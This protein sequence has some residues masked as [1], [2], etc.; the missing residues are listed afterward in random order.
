MGG[1]GHPYAPADLHLPGFVPQQLSQGQILARYLGTSVIVF[2]AVWLLSG[3]CR[4]L[5]KTDRLLMCWWAFTGLTHIFIEG[6]FVFTPGFFRKENPNYLDEVWK[7][8]S[9]AD[10]RYVA[11]DPAIV[12]VEGSTAVLGGPASLLA[13]YAIAS[14]KSYSHILQFTVC[15]GHLYGGL[16]Y[17]I[18]AYLDGFNFWISPFYFWA[19]FISAN[20]FWVWIPTLIAMRSWKMICAAFRAEMAKKTK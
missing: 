16:V 1:D 18:T 12:T 20:S 14:H 4:G 2:L 17:F 15:M 9:K 19:Y 13:V 3:R 8:Y 11:R 7:E 10:S 5:S 6:P